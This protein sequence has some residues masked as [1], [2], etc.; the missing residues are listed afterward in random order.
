M[1]ATLHRGNAR[2]AGV[3]FLVAMTSSLTGGTLIQAV[4]DQPDVLSRLTDESSTVIAGIVLELVNALAVIGIVA[5]LWTPLSRSHPATTVGYLGVR[6]IEAT[7]CAAAALLPLTQLSL[8]GQPDHSG[9]ESAVE[10]LSIVRSSMVSYAVPIFF[11]I[12]AALLYLLLHRSALVPR[13]ITIWG[14]IG[15]AGVMANVFVSEPAIQPI[16]VLPIIANEIYLG[17]YLISRGL[18][19]PEQ[20]ANAPALT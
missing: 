14:L 19:R 10:L 16:L 2:F 6:I 4:L 20:R 17:V 11:G 9:A 3:M 8:A 15:A 5:A 1:S 12:G 18:R 13:Y 7:V